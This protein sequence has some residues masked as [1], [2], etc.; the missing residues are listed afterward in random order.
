[1]DPVRTIE[2]QCELLGATWGWWAATLGSLGDADWHRPTRLEGWDVAA[3][4]AHHSLLVPVL[5][6]LARNPVDDAPP[7]S[8]AAA[9]LR[10]FNEPDGVAHTLAHAVAEGARKMAS[11]QTSE[12]LV[13]V[14][15][16]AAPASIDAARHAGAVVVEY[17]RHGRLPLAD[18]MSIMIMEGVVHGLDLVRAVDRPPE[19]PAGALQFTARLLT[20]LADPVTFV[21]AATGRIPAEVF[22]VIR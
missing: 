3:L 8:T 6:R 7:T 12:G 17:F 16:T 21:E 20:D 13:A 5:A 1:M 22:P 18:A 4:V 11:T 10:R 2:E 14:F 15:T 19:P 9:M